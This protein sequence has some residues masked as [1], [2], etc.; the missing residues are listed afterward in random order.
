[1]PS[2]LWF[3][4]F[5]TTWYDKK[6][7]IFQSSFEIYFDLTIPIPQ[8]RMVIKR[9]KNIKSELDRIL[10]VAFTGLGSSYAAACSIFPHFSQG[11]AKCSIKYF[12]KCNI[13][14]I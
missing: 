1:M 14:K 5:L 7:G 10:T 3:M 9:K 12:K 6:F 13:N 11:T 8:S 4:Q 2:N